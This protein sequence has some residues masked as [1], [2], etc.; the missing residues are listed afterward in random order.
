MLVGVCDPPCQNGGQCISPGY[1][2]CADG[3]RGYRCEEGIKIK[4]NK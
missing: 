2:S 4:E 1:C 3:W